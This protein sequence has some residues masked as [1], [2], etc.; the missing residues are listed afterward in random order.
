MSWRLLAR[1]CTGETTPL[2]CQNRKPEAQAR[3]LFDFT[4]ILGI[5]GWLRACH[6]PGA[7]HQN[8]EKF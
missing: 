5:F 6:H 1:V 3:C 8:V 2:S 7:A 4:P